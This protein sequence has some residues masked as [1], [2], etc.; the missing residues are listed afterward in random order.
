MVGVLLAKG[1]EKYLTYSKL[2][3]FLRLKKCFL[4]KKIFL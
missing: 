1:D 4:E 2:G 3:N